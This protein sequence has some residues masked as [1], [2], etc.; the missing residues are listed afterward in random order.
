M[1][2]WITALLDPAAIAPRPQGSE[3]TLASALAMLIDGRLGDYARSARDNDWPDFGQPAR[4]DSG[5]GMRLVAAVGQH[6]AGE[7]NS[8]DQLSKLALD[9]SIPSDGATAAAI[10]AGM[11]ANDVGRSQTALQIL[12][13]RRAAVDDVLERTVLDVQIGLRRAEAGALRDALAATQAATSEASRLRSPRRLVEALRVVAQRNAFSFS[14]QLGDMPRAGRL[15]TSALLSELTMR[16][17]TGLDAF[18][19]N[20]FMETVEDPTTLTFTMR[21]EDPV[22][23]PLIGSLLRAECLGDWML[24]RETRKRLGRYQLLASLGDVSRA[25]DPAFHLLRRADDT[26]GLKR[27]GRLYHFQGP[28]QSLRAV[29]EAVVLAPWLRSEIASNLVVLRESADTLRPQLAHAAT[30]RLVEGASDFLGLVGPRRTESEF[31]YALAGLVGVSGLPEYQTVSQW[32]RELCS[33]EESAILLQPAA[34]AVASLPWS[35]LPESERTAWAEFA[36]E[37]L[38]APNDRRFVA[39]AASIG[40]VHAGEPRMFDAIVESFRQ[41]P[42]LD[43][44]GLLLSSPI[45]LPQKLNTDIGRMALAAMRAIRTKAASGSYSLGSIIDPARMVAFLLVE[46][47]IRSGWRELVGFLL[48]GK[49]GASAKSR[50][51]SYLAHN[52]K[53]IP[54]VHA[55]RL[56]RVWPVHLPDLP[57][58]PGHE[59]VGAA[60]RLALAT[61]GLTDDEALGSLLELTAAPDRRL[62]HQAA[63]SLRFAAARP[64][65]APSVIGTALSLT[66][67]RSPEVRGVAGQALPDLAR[68]APDQIKAVVRGRLAALLLDPGAFVPTLALQG[69]RR[70]SE[71][72][73]GLVEIV[74]RLQQESLSSDVR[75]AATDY[76]L[77]VAH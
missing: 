63:L 39:N 2:D 6:L 3:P 49:V 52:A 64:T 22:E 67:D 37:H 62:R 18:L 26:E 44:G 14:W 56:R 70:G 77:S 40:L 27:A 58:E 33:Q 48:D 31:M 24:I 47:K 12:E 32:L 25:P 9:G 11:A 10:L 20:Q 41:Q 43:T 17:T 74:Q 45:E 53:R 68:D 21:S 38:G 42:A 8:V 29:G 69:I 51:I 1:T 19:T 15:G 46:R 73:P 50:T 4:K 59:L 7:V 28:L 34:T 72:D 76:L 30:I 61:G 66:E 54:D 35:K 55:R 16:A 36:S 23:S 60:F 5:A 71:T 13:A 65:L 75:E 57:F